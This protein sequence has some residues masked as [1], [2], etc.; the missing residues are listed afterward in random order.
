M[1][2][3]DL[4]SHSYSHIVILIDLALLHTKHYVQ[5]MNE[6]GILSHVWNVFSFPYNKTIRWTDEKKMI[7]SRDWNLQLV[8]PTMQ[9]VQCMKKVHRTTDLDVLEWHI[10]LERVSWCAC[11][12]E[13]VMHSCRACLSWGMSL[14]CLWQDG[15]SKNRFSR[16][17]EPI[18][19]PP[20]VK[21]DKVMRAD[22]AW[23]YLTSEPPEAG[24]WIASNRNRLCAVMPVLYM[25]MSGGGAAARRSVYIHRICI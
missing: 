4:S 24:T 12:S 21:S 20:P 7:L 22:G 3:I 18:A 17:K 8:D 23:F 13:C 5:H 2:Q 11:V 6:L 14:M 15:R 9:Y 10:E 25:L 19:S 16:P 1:K